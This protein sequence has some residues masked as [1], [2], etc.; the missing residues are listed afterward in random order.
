MQIVFFANRI[1]PEYVAKSFKNIEGICTNVSILSQDKP[2]ANYKEK[3]ATYKMSS[4]DDIFRVC[5]SRLDHCLIAPLGTV[6]NL[7]IIKYSPVLEKSELVTWG[8]QKNY[9]VYNKFL[10][11]IKNNVYGLSK[12]A[13]QKI[14]Q[15]KDSFSTILT[16]HIPEILCNL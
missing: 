2:N 6:F 3:F 7:D 4:I 5:A 1:S 9:V 12:Q 14:I 15:N 8:F 16:T 10:D 11:S 13:S